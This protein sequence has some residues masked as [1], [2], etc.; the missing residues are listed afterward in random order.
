MRPLFVGSLAMAVIVVASNILVQ[1]PLGAWLTWGALTYPFSFLVTDLTNRLYGPAAARRVVVAGFLTGLVCSAVGTQ[2]VGASGPLVTLRIAIGSG[3]AFLVAQLLDVT[4]FD[5]MRRRAW[6]QAPLI[7]TLI[8]ST[9]DTAIFFSV[10]F[11]ASLSFIDPGSDVS[12]AGSASPVLGVGPDAPYW[13]SLAVADW[14]VKILLAVVALLPFRLALAR[15][16]AKVA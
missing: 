1:R 15:L 4:V 16:A 3:L 10:A 9:L 14:G 8:G 2:I 13:V 11:A 6:W 5:R 12:W 7:S